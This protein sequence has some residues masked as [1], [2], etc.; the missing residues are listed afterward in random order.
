MADVVRAEE[1][2]SPRDAAK[3]RAV[4][5]HLVAAEPLVA[6]SRPF[7]CRTTSPSRRTAAR[8]ESPV[9][10]PSAALLRTAPRRRAPRAR[11]PG[12]GER[13]QDEHAAPANGD[14]AARRTSRKRRDGLRTS[15][16]CE[17][18]LPGVRQC[19]SE[20]GVPS[21][22]GAIVSPGAR[23]SSPS[24]RCFPA[25]R[26]PRKGWP[27]AS[28]TTRPCSARRRPRSRLLK[29]LNV[30]VVR[31]TL[32]WGGRDGVANKRP[33]TPTD[34]ADPAYEWGRY[35]RAIEGASRAGMEVL[36]TIVG[37]PAW[38]NGGKAPQRR[39][40]LRDDPPRVRLRRRAALQ[41]HVPR[42]GE[43]ED[44]P[45]GRA[46]GSPGTSRTALC[47]F[48]RSSSAWAAS[49][50]WRRRPP[51]RRSATPSTAGV[52]AAGGPERVACG[53][54]APRGHNDATSPRPSIAPLTFLQR[55]QA[56]GPPRLR[57]LG[58]PPVLRRPMG[59]PGDAQRRLAR[60]RARRHR[61]ADLRGDEPVR[62]QA[63]LDHRVRLPDE[64]AGR[65]L[66]RQLDEAGR[67]TF[68]RRS[69]SRGRTRASTSS[70]GSCSRTARRPTAGNRG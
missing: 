63:A 66:R 43:R 55:G 7:R 40:E 25:R 3:R 41:R 50:A 42:H 39:A 64:A 65:H 49:G 60:D 48:S 47:S 18:S 33:A 23:C 59:D 24:S 1:M 9:P 56:D 29:S 27:S 68:A 69:R 5:S 61:H 67:S 2:A 38:A 19:P 37:T 22:D 32:T 51:T 54:T 30:Q 31:M 21:P 36:L 62:P 16:R 17:R 13:R 53:A 57:R 6:C 70:R 15:P 14:D 8:P 28:S 11:R 44:P 12:R 35:D 4:R 10:R 58:A 46:C 34:P 20:P 45:A 52:H 26:R